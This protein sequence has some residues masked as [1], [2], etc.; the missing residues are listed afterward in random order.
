MSQKGTR[1]NALSL[2]SCPVSRE[3]KIQPQHQGHL[4][5]NQ[6]D[7]TQNLALEAMN[8]PFLCFR[9]NLQFVGLHW[10]PSTGSHSQ[11]LCQKAEKGMF[12]YLK[13]IFHIQGEKL[14]PSSHI[15]QP[16]FQSWLAVSIMLPGWHLLKCTDQMQAFQRFAF[17]L[18]SNLVLP[19]EGD[20]IHHGVGIF[21]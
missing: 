10:T 6:A 19:I 17:P 11:F 21:H 14:Y 1:G 13:G 2:L 7:P 12:L 4:L 5:Q 15:P 8:S 18:P 16:K 3:G 9:R 20:Y